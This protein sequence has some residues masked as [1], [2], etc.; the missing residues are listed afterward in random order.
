VTK[1]VEKVVIVGRDAPGWIAAAA[2]QHALGRTGVS[3]RVI[4]LPSLLQ[5]P[6]VYSAVPPL[7]GLHDQL[8]LDERLILGAC[9]GVPMVGQRFSNWS[10]PAA[11]FIHGYD[12][13][14]PPESD[15]DFTQYWIKGRQQGLRSAFENF[16]LGAMAAKAGRVPTGAADPQQPLTA[17]YGYHLDARRYSVLMKEVAVRRGV[18]TKTASIAGVELEGERIRSLSL[19]D[20]EQVDADLFIDASGTEATLIGHLPGAEF[21]SWREWLPC[22]RMIVASGNRLQPPPA[23]SQISAFRDGWIGIFPLQDRAAV[24]GVFDSRLRSDREMVESLPVIARLPIA[25][26]AVVSELRQGIRD[27]TWVGNCVAVGEAAFS[28]EPLDGVQLHIAHSCISHLMAFFPVETSAFP[29]AAVY[30]RGVRSIAENMR[31]FQAAHYMLNRRFD[32][33]FWDRCRDV[34][35]PMTLQSR[36]DLF[37]ARGDVS[38]YQSEAFAAQDWASLFLGHG[39]MPETCDP[40]VDLIPEEDHIA[41]VHQRLQDIL[42]LVGAMPPVDEFLANAVYQN[43]PEVAQGG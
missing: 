34:P 11:P 22:D 6:D 5:G 12:D 20:G 15:L 31:D 19:S 43:R 37:A 14:P 9:N 29:E 28:L 25:G 32:D 38:L 18:A 1:R 35:C 40:R 7:K 21:K 16:S 4:E 42:A 33:P 23:F 41:K 3:V 36:I 2:I 13:Q 10:G 30:D 27:S 8:R 26:D 24:V 17:G 39:L